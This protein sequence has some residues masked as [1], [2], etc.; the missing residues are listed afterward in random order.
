[1][2]SFK[3]FR[4]ILATGVALVAFPFAAMA[5]NDDRPSLQ[6]SFRL[7]GQQGVLCQVQS[8]SLDPA[9]TGMFDRS[10]AIVCRDAAT[11]VGRVYAL[12]AGAND[13]SARLQ[14]IRA[15]I[16]T[17]TAPTGRASLPDIGDVTVTD[18]DLKGNDVDYRVYS[19]QRGK[20]LYVAEGLAGYD[21]AL[22]LALRTIATD[23]MIEGTVDV[24]TTA[25]S[26]PAAFARVQ[27]GSLDIDTALAEG[28]RRNNS[29]SYAE[30]AEFFDTLLQRAEGGKVSQAAL[31][32][33]VVNRALQRSNLGEFSEAEAL[34]QQASLIPT[35]DPVQLRLRRNFTVMHLINQRKLDDAT[36][37]LDRKLAAIGIVGGPAAAGV[38]DADVAAGLN[39]SA[40]LIR[41]LGGTETTSLTEEEKAAILDAQAL[42]LRGTVLRLEGKAVPARAALTST[43]D[44]LMAIRGGRVTS[45]TR[46]RAQTM[47]E[48]SAIAESSGNQGEAEALLRNGLALLE[49]EYP[50]SVAVAAAK[51]RL[52][53]YLSRR[54]Q[55]QAALNLYRDV[56]RSVTD[57]GTT[58]AGFENLIAPYFALLT[59]LMPRQ[60]SLV[61]DFF[62]ASET[63]VRPGVADTQAVL[64]RELSGGSD[65]AARLFRQSVTL[66]RDI[67]RSRIELAR[68][69]ALPSPNADDQARM[70]AL[71]QSL[72]GLE[73]DQVATQSK[74]GQYPRYR[75]VS[76][77]A[78]AL[79][80]LQKAL[81]PG[82]G[83]LKLV[84]V[85]NAIYG[86]WATPDTA[87]A[88]RANISAADLDRKVDALRDT[89]SVEENGERLTYPF[90]LRLAREL[91]VDLLAPIGDRLN[92]V[93]HLIF[94]P[95]GG[96][97][98]LPPA[99]L[100]T[101]QAGVDAYYAR[102]KKPKADDF[103][104]RGV[105][106]LAR[107]AD[108]STAVSARAFRDVRGAAPSA[109]KH[110]FLGLGQN[111]PVSPFVQ[112]TSSRG[113]SSTGAIDCDWPLAAWNSPIQAT[114][115]KTAQTIIGGG[116]SAV[117]TGADFTDTAVMTKPDLN[118]YRILHFATH[119]LVTAP[120][121]EC[122]AR[123][124]LLTSF[125]GAQSDGLLTFKEIYDLRLDAD[126]VILS[127][128]DTAGKA[129]VAATREAGITSGGGN[130]LDGLVRAFIGAGGRSVLASHW[131]APDDFKA[132]ERLIASLYE[133]KPGTSVAGALRTGQLM[134]M[135]DAPTSHPYYWS[136][137][138]II[139]DGAQPVLK[140]R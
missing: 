72:R 120:R 1:M 98:R 136:D 96:M 6:D 83:Y 29:G 48:L 41:Q 103:D 46:L 108:I 31:G 129:T 87:T 95:A 80:D 127:A 89:I 49:G 65:E 69:D 132:T 88:Y 84:L 4:A 90:N 39:S 99:L 114:E 74:L 26:D 57:I 44:Q 20:T 92:G 50:R 85:S 110:E 56:I 64:A 15:G 134:L 94:E 112:L 115:L 137:F 123:P 121:P 133:A 7:G 81:R 135:D 60:P 71:R 76:T 117:I 52:A 21:S 40:P 13:P 24:A 18:C 78:M 122:P 118:Q 32:E 131:P 14:A 5:A 106:W 59:R 28:Y 19:V 38:I 3:G 105:A 116:N 8:S 67:E 53:A 111:A 16:T 119:G 22:T 43:L 70:T 62:L 51:A 37:E 17:C 104:F 107:K 102:L 9:I 34:F 79:G 82:E 68:L 140:H 130:A 126:L 58:T 128:C 139:G 77:Q 11:P 125:G 42:Q 27:A 63:L 36:A 12:R 109:A 45:I 54:G 55:D 35:A 66:T 10:Y 23:R 30:A 138:V 86:I 75:A 61:Q 73:T 101:D 2:R 124:A 113:V 47:A 91:Y 33:Y 25:V 97:L 93:G 100:V